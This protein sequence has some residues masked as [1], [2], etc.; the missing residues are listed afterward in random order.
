MINE[1]IL[2]EEK[3]NVIN[4]LTKISMQDLIFA[5]SK[6]RYF[7]NKTIII[8]GKVI[9]Y[10]GIGVDDEPQQEK[11]YEVKLY[12]RLVLK[13]IKMRK[14]KIIKEPVMTPNMLLEYFEK[15]YED[16]YGILLNTSKSTRQSYAKKL[17]K[18]MDTF[19]KNGYDQKVV[20][21]YVKRCVMFGNYKGDAI[22]LGWICDEN[23]INSYLLI[24]NGKKSVSDLW[25]H[26]DVTIS[27]IEKRKIKYYMNLGNWDTFSNDEK[28]ICM[29]LYK[30][31]DKI[32]FEELKNKHTYSNGFYAKVKIYEVLSGE[33]KLNMSELLLKTKHTDKYFQYEYIKDQLV[34]VMTKKEGRG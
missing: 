29:K 22:Y 32:T 25:R 20:K 33:E 23:T 2:L 26:L 16:N 28:Q 9:E 12:S 8:N 11:E 10:K 6:Y 13:P 34:E 5:L 7:Y 31:Y 17:E 1:I 24:L 27:P 4:C 19:Y 18:V 15:L 30:I 3:D 21:K 14:K